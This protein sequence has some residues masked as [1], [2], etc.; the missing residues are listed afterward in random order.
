MIEV[1]NC[2]HITYSCIK[3]VFILDLRMWN[4]SL[5]SSSDGIYVVLLASTIIIAMENTF[6]P[7]LQIFSRRN[8]YFCSI[9]LYLFH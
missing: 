8:I 2:I 4:W 7:S 9:L 5:R 3:V 1:R 6:Q